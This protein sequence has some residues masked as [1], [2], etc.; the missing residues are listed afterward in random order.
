MNNDEM[1][2]RIREDKSIRL[3]FQENGEN[4]TKVISVDTLIECIK[5]SLSGIR[6]STGLL[7]V[8]ALSVT[9]D[10]DH[11]QRYVTMEFPDETATVTYMQTEY[12]NFPLPRLLFG[13]R[14]EKSGRIS[15]VNMGVPALGKL[16]P[17]TQMFY[18]PFSNV[19]R[20]SLCTGANT[21]PHIQSLQ[22]LSNLPYFILSL[23][24]NDDHYTDQNNRLG[25]GHRDLMEHLR[26]KDRNYY[27]EHVLLPMPNV[28]LNHFI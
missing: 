18:Y 22:Q 1:L 9:V 16:T 4:R 26:D 10:T 14:I 25:L 6:I 23:P 12:P 17:D 19:S 2:L 28:T 27:Y 15:G 7:P 21:L 20:F 11:S 5:N 13:F 8:N 24:D 3:E